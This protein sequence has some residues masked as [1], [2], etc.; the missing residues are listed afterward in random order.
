MILKHRKNICDVDE[1][2]IFK[3]DVLE[4]M[5]GNISP[6]YIYVDY[7]EILESFSVALTNYSPI[8]IN[9][10]DYWNKE[11]LD[12]TLFVPENPEWF[13]ISIIHPF[14]FD[15]PTSSSVN[16]SE[17]IECDDFHDCSENEDLD[18]LYGLGFYHNVSK[19]GGS[20]TDLR[21]HFDPQTNPSLCPNEYKDRYFINSLIGLQDK[22]AEINMN[23]V[24]KTVSLSTH[25]TKTYSTLKRLTDRMDMDSE[26]FSNLNDLFTEDKFLSNKQYIAKKGTPVA[27]KYMGQNANDA[28]LQGDDTAHGSYFMDIK[29]DNIFEYSVESNLLEPIYE[30]FIKPL[31]HPLGMIYKYR[32]VCTDE[33]ANRTE[34]PLIIKDYSDTTV[35]VNCLCFSDGQ[36]D[37]PLPIQPENINC[38]YNTHFEDYPD[39]KIFA[40]PN[41]EDLWEPIKNDQNIPKSFEEGLE[42]TGEYKNQYFKKY[43]FNNNNYLISYTNIPGINDTS[44]RVTIL[45]Y[46]Y[47]GSS[48]DL[49]A[50]FINQRHCSIQLIGEPKNVS[51]IDDELTGLCENILNGTFQ[52]LDKNEGTL[53]DQPAPSGLYE[54]FM[55]TLGGGALDRFTDLYFGWF[56]FLDRN[57]ELIKGFSPSGFYEGF[58]RSR[59]YYIEEMI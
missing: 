19:T 20:L 17:Q 31:T 40:S 56:Q 35:A 25:D 6:Y 13:K 59:L 27:I 3:D 22:L 37:T 33:I 32:T 9:I 49:T 39:P 1:T 12:T 14:E 18:E 23:N 58:D 8:S 55:G 50:K 36:E 21:N 48:Y 45:Y 42:T 47:N 16:C 52:F 5:M 44:E 57:E 7:K 15:E 29:T 34:T 43:I 11:I 4:S 51:D 28:K 2:I 10:T 26:L 41:G 30:S 54:G 24:Y 53:P 46:R 38:V